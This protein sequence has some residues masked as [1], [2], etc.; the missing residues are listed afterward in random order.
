MHTCACAGLSQESCQ[1]LRGLGRHIPYLDIVGGK[2]S[3]KVKDLEH[4]S[5]T[6]VSDAIAL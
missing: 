2:N 5:S 1:L 3:A 6:V 4:G